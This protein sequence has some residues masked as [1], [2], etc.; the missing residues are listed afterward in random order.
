M[1]KDPREVAVRIVSETGD[2]S[3]ASYYSGISDPRDRALAYGLAAG[4][5]KWRSLI[6]R[7]LAAFSSRSLASLRAGVLA[8]LRVGAFQLLFT[9]IPTY[10]AVDSV[11]R[12]QRDPRLR[13]FCNGVLRSVARASG[14]IEIPSLDKDPVSYIEARYSHPGFVA[15][16]LVD[17][18]GVSEALRLAARSNSPPPLSLRIARSGVLRQD[19]LA[20]LRAQGHAAREGATPSFVHLPTG[21]PVTLLPGFKE[22]LFSVQDEGAA[23]ISAAVGPRAGDRVWDVCAAPGGKTAHLA[24][25]LGGTGEVVATDIDSERVSMIEDTVRRLGLRGVSTAVFDATNEG[26]SSGLGTFDRI[27]LDAPCSGLGVLRRHPD[28]RWNRRES[29][30]PAMARR[31]AALLRAAAPRLRSGGILV[32]STCT[33]TSEENEGVWLPFLEEHKEFVPVDP[34][35]RAGNFSVLYSEKL[36]GDGYRYILADTYDSDCFFVGCAAREASSN[37]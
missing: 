8:A 21:S 17:R 35:G 28:L 9:D 31:Q 33:L 36:A 20:L 27:L 24:E 12:L 37:A 30:I 22:G 6:D 10:A 29:D 18:F 2:T 11:V 34:K 5:L 4:T 7:H 3:R 26:A 32:Y 14:H 19:Y 1:Q 15:Q 13:G 16:L 25:M 23:A